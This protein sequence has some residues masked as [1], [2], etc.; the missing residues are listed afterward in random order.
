MISTESLESGLDEE[1]EVSEEELCVPG[2]GDV[3][4]AFFDFGDPGGG[5]VA[6][7]FACATRRSERFF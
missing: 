7:D 4:F 1:L 5:G 2:G 3:G 6:F